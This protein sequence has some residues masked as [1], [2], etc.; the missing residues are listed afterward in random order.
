MDRPDERLSTESA[1]VHFPA[2]QSVI[3]LFA[4]IVCMYVVVVVVVVQATHKECLT[5]VHRSAE[6][7]A[8]S[9]VCVRE[10]VRPFQTCANKEDQ[11]S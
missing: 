4:P 5:D 2:S 6:C 8:C 11:R 1:L 9:I 3:I 10:F 7:T